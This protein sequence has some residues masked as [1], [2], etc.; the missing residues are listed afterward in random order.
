MA[1]SSWTALRRLS[2]RGG[3]EVFEAQGEGGEA[4]VV[5]RAAPGGGS[6]VTRR[7]S[8]EIGLWGMLHHPGLAAVRASGED[9]IAF[10]RLGPSLAEPDMRARHAAPAAARS[11][12]TR[13]ADT[14][15]YLHARGI[16]HR[17]IKPAHVMF[18]ESEPVLIDL[19]LAALAGSDPVAGSEVAGAP[20]WMSPEAVTGAVPSASDDSWSLC[21]I[22]AWLV[23]GAPLY[24]G[25]AH[26]VL[27][28]RGNGDGPNLR[29]GQCRDEDKE[30]A[31]IIEAGLGPEPARP[32]AGEIV[33]AL[34]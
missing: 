1:G 3:V 17:D 29:L 32:R 16:V 15:A 18:R 21:A 20:A 6:D 28:A 30:L 9:W 22:G 34:S 13:L 14:L 25:S 31:A 2:R 27:A 12:I 19:G 26:V 24:A 5:K 33:R 7:M 4:I 11:L 10:E 23:G 8:R